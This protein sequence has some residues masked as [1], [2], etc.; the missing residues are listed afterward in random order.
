MLLALV[1]LLP[2]SSPR[3]V[4]DI[5][6]GWQC[7]RLVNFDDDNSKEPWWDV[8]LPHYASLR[9]PEESGIAQG[10]A[11]YRRTLKFSPE[12]LKRHIELTLEGAM[13]VSTVWLN[14]QQIGGR[15]G[16][17]L[18]VIVDL[19]DRAKSVNELLVR[20]DNR[21]NPLV[22][23]GKP[24]QQVDFMYGWGLYRNA[25]LTVTGRTHVLTADT[26]DLKDG[27][28]IYITTES[29]SADLA[30]V[31]LR[32][33][34][35]FA[36]GQKPTVVEEVYDADAKPAIAKRVVKMGTG[37]L[38]LA[39][40]EDPHIDDQWVQ[41]ANP[42]LWSPDSP[43]LYT[44]KTTLLQNGEPVDSVTTKFGIRKIEVSR[45]KGFVLNGKPI[46]LNGTNRHQDY[47]WAGPALSDAA[48]ARDALMIKR[49][50]HNIVRLSHYPQSPA[51]LDACDRYGLMVIPCIP[52]W[53]FFNQ[54]PRFE[55][56]VE[57][58]IRGLI[59]R[60]RNHPCVAF[61]ETSLNETYPPADLAK[62][63]YDCAKS[64][65][66]DDNILLAGDATKGAPWDI[67]YNG[68]KE[69]LSRP[70]NDL[71]D[72]PGYIRE[73]GDYEFGGAKSSS[74][75]RIRQGLDPLLGETWN[76]LWSLNKFIT[77]YPW[78]MGAG[79]WEMF[80][81]NVPWDFSV[82]ASGLADI[83]RREKPSYWFYQSQFTKT[84]FTKVLAHWQP[85]SPHR[86]VLVFTNGKEVK[87]SVNGKVVA[88]GKPQRFPSRRYDPSKPWGESD[89]QNLPN[90]PI[91][92]NHIPFEAGTL[93][94]TIDGASDSITTAG[95]PVRVKTW[96]DDLG[97]PV[98]GNDVVF[99][100]AA[101][102]DANGN[103]CT[104]FSGT[105]Y[106]QVD[107]AEMMGRNERQAE[108]GIA[109]FVLRTPMTLG[110]IQATGSLEPR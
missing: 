62:K 57:S 4:I 90:P 69:D 84:P 89:T 32:A 55:T 11:F 52:G 82:S 22:P 12:Q 36:E 60:D 68:W 67:G 17:Y 110:Q 7:T 48:N 13:Q 33:E 103:V 98:T 3:E 104:D 80:D 73:Y 19:T 23:P 99:L 50:G 49:A 1:A 2:S 35:Q 10:V 106:V 75:V 108:M 87:L 43:Y 100:R 28:G 96:I 85:G 81:H 97:V 77:Q 63:W 70:Q 34:S 42:H 18:P 64:E 16:G 72:K 92:F 93:T 29:A 95:E 78:T 86:W 88:T 6:G 5:D 66:M 41:I 31:H 15:Q 61:W 54:D 8:N 37:D 45:K 14:G 102:V 9:E 44:L 20:V 21:D 59:R 76:H 38:A 101:V 24:Q 56:A 30:M 94:A 40:K 65:A 91:V 58:D 109:S 79:T 25:Y 47:P 74:R 39:D 71:P 51:F 105:V 46:Y 83:Y 53:Q 107:G 26:S 27:G